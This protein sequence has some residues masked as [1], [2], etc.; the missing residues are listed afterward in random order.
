MAMHTCPKCGGR[1]S[2]PRYCA[3]VPRTWCSMREPGEHMHRT[4]GAC[5]FEKVEPTRDNREPTPLEKMAR[6]APGRGGKGA[7]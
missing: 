5:G 3:G 2:G 4:C 6:S 1:L 7:A